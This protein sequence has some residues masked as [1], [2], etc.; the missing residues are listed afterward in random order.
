MWRLFRQCTLATPHQQLPH[1]PWLRQAFRLNV[2]V[3]LCR[4]DLSVRQ[5]TVA[6]VDE[7]AGAPATHA[8]AAAP[9]PVFSTE[10]LIAVDDG[11]VAERQCDGLAIIICTRR[12][13]SFGCPAVLVIVVDALAV[14]FAAPAVAHNCNVV[15]GVVAAAVVFALLLLGISPLGR[16]AARFASSAGCRLAC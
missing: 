15:I 10:L 13:I 2:L 4:V 3:E 16:R 1:A 12:S 8:H 6:V 11:R 14:T 9:L 7:R 5:R